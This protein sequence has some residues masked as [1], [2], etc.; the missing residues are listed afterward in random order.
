MDDVVNLENPTEL[1][2]LDTNTKD[3]HLQLI[4]W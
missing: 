1:K 2:G 4:Y 3:S